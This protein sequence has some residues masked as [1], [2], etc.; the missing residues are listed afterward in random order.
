[1]RLTCT[2]ENK[3]LAWSTLI[4]NVAGNALKILYYYCPRSITLQILCSSES[5][6]TNRDDAKLA[7]ILSF[8]ILAV[9][10]SVFHN[11]QF[12]DICQNTDVPNDHFKK[13]S[14]QKSNPIARNKSGEIFIKNKT[15]RQGFIN[16]G[17]PVIRMFNYASNFE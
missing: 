11:K 9:I 15:R 12:Q 17:E 14:L 4:D 7:A 6:S 3:L 16:F 8:F 5:Q 2:L 1:M 10:L 13:F